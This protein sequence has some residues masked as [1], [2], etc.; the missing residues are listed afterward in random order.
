MWRVW[1]SKRRDGK[2]VERVLAGIT[3]RYSSNNIYHFDE[4]GCLW[5]ALSESRFGIKGVRCHGG[6]KS[7]HRFTVVLIVNADGEN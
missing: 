5:W 4:T 3:P 2:I 7:K 6:K 1:G